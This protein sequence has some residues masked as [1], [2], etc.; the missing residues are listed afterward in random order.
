MMNTGMVGAKALSRSGFYRT[1]TNE[2]LGAVT[3]PSALLCKTLQP[4]TFC[5]CCSAAEKGAPLG[6]TLS[7]IVR[8]QLVRY[9]SVRHYGGI[10][11]PIGGVGRIPEVL[12]EGEQC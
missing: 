4:L 10:N 2:G 7:C 1:D 8:N 6:R 3:A 12:A 11:Y 9:H 5:A